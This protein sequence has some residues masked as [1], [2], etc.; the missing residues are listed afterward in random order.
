MADV[1][2][3]LDGFD[4]TGW[5]QVQVTRS[6][7]QIADQ[8]S[9]SIATTEVDR[10][11]PGQVVEVLL[12]G[13]R[14]LTGYIDEDDVT[15][16]AEQTTLTV[17]GRSRAG[18]LVDCSAIHRPW[19]GVAGLAIAQA[20]CEPF[21]V[22]VTTEAGPLADEAYFKVN[23]GETVFD[24]LDRLARANAMRIVSGIDGGVIFTR[25]GLLRYPDVVIRRG[26]NVVSGHR[27][28]SMAERY[29]DYVFKAQ[30]AASDDN[31]GE[32]ANA[33]KYEVQDLGVDRWRPLVV[34]TDT[35]LG[36]AVAT[37]DGKQT[38]NRLVAAAAW[39]R[40]TRAARALELEYD[41]ADPLN[42]SASWRCGAHGVWEPNIIVGVQDD[43]LGIAGEFLVRQVT[44]V[45]DA[46]GT[47]TQVGLVAP[48]AYAVQDPP[49]P[50]KKKG[51]TAW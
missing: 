35:Q 39:E 40:N 46:Q 49:K 50:K 17:S 16:S 36:H 26:H 34:Q 38:S 18:D 28:R 3:R 15:Y 8:F 12:D 33:A 24:A 45:R 47:R 19:R 41:V 51:G 27:R 4:L 2:L 1:A 5:T 30:V 22:R 13:E 44:L 31:F 32:S 42:M 25:T 6:L 21:Q 48:E 7:D 20:L 23:E 14:V 11:I 37:I 29:S 10:F 43:F 9:L